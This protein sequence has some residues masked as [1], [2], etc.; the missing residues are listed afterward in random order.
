MFAI[1]LQL[2]IFCD[3]SMHSLF[4]KLIILGYFSLSESTDRIKNLEKLW[5][6]YYKVVQSSIYF[7]GLDSQTLQTDS[8]MSRVLKCNFLPHF[9]SA[10][11]S[12]I[13]ISLDVY[14]AISPAGVSASRGLI[15]STD[16]LAAKPFSQHLW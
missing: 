10:F 8:L 14:G 9:S 3:G 2:Q 1:F 15:A 7:G 4:Y 13:T 5:N 12:D 6:K 16:S 11:A